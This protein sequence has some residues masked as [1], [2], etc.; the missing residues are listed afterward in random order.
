MVT[1]LHIRVQ[2]KLKIV[3]R[4]IHSQVLLELKANA[5]TLTWV[6][7]TLDANCFR[8][9][10]DWLELPISA[11]IKELF[12]LPNSN[13]GLGFHLFKTLTKKMR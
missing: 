13:G 12:I 1:G 10:L 11:C 2:D 5:L 4:Y 9:I 7:Q 3:T 8:F 6:E